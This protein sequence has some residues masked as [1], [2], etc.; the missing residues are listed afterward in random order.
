MSDGCVLLGGRREKPFA[1]SVWCSP[2]TRWPS[3]PRT[4]WLPIPSHALVHPH[5]ARQYTSTSLITNIELM[6]MR[7]VLHPCGILFQ[8][9]LRTLF[10]Y[11]IYFIFIC[12]SWWQL[13][14]A[15]GSHTYVI[16]ERFGFNTNTPPAHC[17]IISFSLSLLLTSG[18]PN[19][20]WA[21][22]VRAYMYKM[23]APEGTR[24]LTYM[25]ISVCMRYKHV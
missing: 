7:Q 13:M 22:M 18:Y 8:A 15:P 1:C 9:F 17:F 24:T 4:R 3:I 23:A 5:L 21:C 2:C 11:T 6:Q 10:S 16:V 14:N 12:S 19:G 20:P 25:L